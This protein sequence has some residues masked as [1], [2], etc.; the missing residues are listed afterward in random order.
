[1]DEHPQARYIIETLTKAGW[2]AYYAGGWVRDFLLGHASDDIDIA[3]NASPEDIQA[4][5]PK[6]V[7]IGIAFGIILVIVEGQE[8]EVATFRNDFDYIDGRRPSRVEF[9]TA[10]E[11]ANRRDFTIN[12]MFYD[13]IK[14]EVLDY[15]KGKLDLK[16]KIIRA[17]GNPHERFRED[18][19]RMIRAV[20]LCC[21]FHFEI[22]ADTATAIKDHAAELFPS[23]AIER[24]VQELEKA[25]KS[26]KLQQVL[27]MLHEFGL[28]QTIFPDLTNTSAQQIKELLEST[29]HF[30][31]KTPLIAHLVQLFPKMEPLEHI[32]FCKR[33]KLPRT[34]FDFV[35]LLNLAKTLIAKNGSA[36]LYDWAQFYALPSSS[37]AVDILAAKL[38]TGREEFVKEHKLRA[39]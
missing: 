19:L 32:E 33:L 10:E 15:V 17:I 29:L 9:T 1:M 35:Q 16:K 26:R 25:H 30:P 22:E 34:E 2:I 36:Q 11:D 7:P 6:T 18:R 27:M 12:G 37:I 39:D 24:V 28:L 5:F 14:E 3:T 38:K 23:V 31:H 13:P 8:Y 20:R 21:R 4:L